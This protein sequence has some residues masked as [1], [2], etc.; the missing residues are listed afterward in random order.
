KQRRWLRTVTL[1]GA[2]VVGVGA[3]C[4]GCVVSQV[5]I[6]RSDADSRPAEESRVLCFGYVDVKHGV[7]SLYPLQP[8]RVAEVLVEENQPVSAGTALM[9]LDDETAQLQV[10]EAQAALESARVQL[11]Q[12]RKLPEQHQAK[13]KQ[14]Q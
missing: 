13:R 2:A 10:Q 6:A 3:A 5:E 12:A 14:L 1:T 8:G 9:R 4:V 11:A 7:R